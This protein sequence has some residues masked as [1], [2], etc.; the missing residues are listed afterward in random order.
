VVDAVSY[1]ESNPNKRE[2]LNY[3]AQIVI[4]QAKTGVELAQCAVLLDGTGLTGELGS[5]LW[6]KIIDRIEQVANSGNSQAALADAGPLG[7]AMKIL[8]RAT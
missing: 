3:F 8:A 4:G 7:E 6:D 2:R 1:W 5:R